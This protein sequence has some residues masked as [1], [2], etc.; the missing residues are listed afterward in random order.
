LKVGEKDK[1][2]SIPS[3]IIDLISFNTPHH[4]Y[5]NTQLYRWFYILFVS[6]FIMF[7]NAYGDRNKWYMILA[8]V[9]SAPILVILGMQC[10]GEEMG[11]NEGIRQRKR[12]PHINFDDPKL[13]GVVASRAFTN[14]R[15]KCLEIPTSFVKA[16]ECNS[17]KTMLSFSSTSR[18]QRLHI[19]K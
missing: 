17:A 5:R 12:N 6:S 10:I 19:R 2:V 4:E 11:I 18:S 1:P 14:V 3:T 8:G 15:G 13:S 16:V 7:P 9:L